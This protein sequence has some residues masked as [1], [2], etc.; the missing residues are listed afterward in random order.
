MLKIATICLLLVFFGCDNAPRVRL[1]KDND[2]TFHFQW[3]KPL[4][5]E[6]IILV[7][8]SGKVGTFIKGEW[9]QGYSSNDE[10]LVYFPA[11]SFVSAPVDTKGNPFKAL[12]HPNGRYIRRIHSVEL[13]A[14]HLRN[15]IYAPA[16][17]HTIEDENFKRYGDQVILREH[18]FFRKYRIGSRRASALLPIDHRLPP[19]SSHQSSEMPQS[20]LLGM[21]KTSYLRSYRFFAAVRYQTLPALTHSRHL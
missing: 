20:P 1:V 17:L 5:E 10:Y 7:R 16:R 19:H 12:I 21:K 9:E 6:P 18:P 11:G 14:P 13:P 8:Y 2:F 4:K 15:T 3:N